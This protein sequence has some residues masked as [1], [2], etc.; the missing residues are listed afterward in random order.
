MNYSKYKRIKVK[1]VISKMIPEE[2]PDRKE[3]IKKLT[4]LEMR[5]RK[6]NEV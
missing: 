2:K 4:T 1:K 3:M 5:I 6:K